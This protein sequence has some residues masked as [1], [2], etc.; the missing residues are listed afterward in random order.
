METPQHLEQLEHFVDIG[1][2]LA[3]QKDQAALLEQILQSAQQISAAD[4]G[5]IYKMTDQGCL[6]FA[7]LI[8]KSL[9][10]HQ[11]GT[12]SVQPAFP[13]IPLLLD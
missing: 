13:D 7:T 8:N 3:R 10:L 4:G 1:L 5:T 11:G 9:G 12:S 6:Q 2:A